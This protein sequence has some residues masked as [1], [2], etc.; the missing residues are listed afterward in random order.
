MKKGGVVGISAKRE[1]KEF[2]QRIKLARIKRKISTAMVCERAG[3]SRSTL[4]HIEQGE[5][6]VAIGSYVAVLHALGGLDRELKKL[7]AEDLTGD[8]L[9]ENELL[10]KRI[11]YAGE[12]K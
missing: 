7:L 3:I 4:W 12:K 10:K 2:G 8:Q 6:T 11:R 9:L 1:L 5:P